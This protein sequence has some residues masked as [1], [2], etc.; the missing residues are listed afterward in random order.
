MTSINNNINI[1][2]I[3]ILI[4]SMKSKI[5]WVDG[6]TSTEILQPKMTKF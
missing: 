5:A 1:I 4:V 3:W 6:S 2:E